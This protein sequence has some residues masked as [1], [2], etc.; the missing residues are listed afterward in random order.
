MYKRQKHFI[1]KNVSFGASLLYRRNTTNDTFGETST[2]SGRSFK[3]GDDFLAD[4]TLSH[5][6]LWGVWFATPYVNLQYRNSQANIE[7]ESESPNSGGQWLSAQAGLQ[8][9]PKQNFNIKLYGQVPFYQSLQ[10]TQIT[11]DYEIGIEINH[12]LQFEKKKLPIAP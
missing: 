11:T 12:K 1:K 8:F 2:S 6:Q 10:G 5:Q 7:E 3:F 9:V 4:V